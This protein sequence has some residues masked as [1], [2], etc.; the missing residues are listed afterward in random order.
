MNEEHIMGNVHLSGHIHD[1]IDRFFQTRVFGEIPDLVE[2]ES[3][4]DPIEIIE[5]NPAQ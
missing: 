2:I 3:I 5:F 4:E 1:L